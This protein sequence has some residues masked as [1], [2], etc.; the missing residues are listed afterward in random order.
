MEEN[1]LGAGKKNAKKYHGWI[2]FLDESGISQRPPVRR[3]WAPRG[4]TP[5]LRHCFNWKKLSIC[6]ALAFGCNGKRS[7]LF[8]QIV[9]ESFNDEK[10]IVFLSGML[11]E[12]KGKKVTIVW[13]GLPSHRSRRMTQYLQGQRKRLSVTRLPSYAPDLNPVEYIWANIK[14]KELANLCSDDLTLMVEGVRKGFTRIH[15]SNHLNHSFLKHAGLSL[16][17]AV[18]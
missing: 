7:R 1:H 18:N 14:G 4:E 16:G 3:I 13:D 2:V 10:L 9:S 17:R 12:F 6:S 11:A 8:F 15:E 5:V